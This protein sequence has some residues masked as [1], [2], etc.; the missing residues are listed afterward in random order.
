MTCSAK[1]FWEL[2]CRILVLPRLYTLTWEK[3]GNH[4]RTSVA[5]QF[6]IADKNNRARII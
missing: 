5:L 6:V 4:H 3:S 2:V 1:Q